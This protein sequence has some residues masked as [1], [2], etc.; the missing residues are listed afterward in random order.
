[1]ED[2]AEKENQEEVDGNIDYN[3]MKMKG[4]LKEPLEV[5]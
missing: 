5:L 2:A 1:M 3:H 4:Y